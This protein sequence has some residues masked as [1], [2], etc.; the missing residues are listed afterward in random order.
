MRLANLSCTARLE[1]P[2]VAPMRAQLRPLARAAFPAP[3]SSTVGDDWVGSGPDWST[4]STSAA[5]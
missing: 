3:K 1:V 2:S 5:G 4:C